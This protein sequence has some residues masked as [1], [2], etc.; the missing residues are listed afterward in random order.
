MPTPDA[1][2]PEDL[3]L[4]APPPVIQMRLAPQGK[5]VAGRFTGNPPGFGV[6]TPA[7]SGIP[8]RILSKSITA[9]AWTGDGQLVVRNSE[10]GSSHWGLQTPGGTPSTVVFSPSD[11]AGW[12]RLLRPDSGWR[13][14]F[15]VEGVSGRV[16]P[17]ASS[18]LW[19]DVLRVSSH[20]GSTT[21]AARNPGD[22]VEWLADADGRV[23]VALAIRG[24]TQELRVRTGRKPETW[25]TV[26][27]FDFVRDPAQLLAL[28]DDGQRAW[29]ASRLGRDTRGVQ[30]LDVQTGRVVRNVFADPDFD[31]DS[32][33]RAVTSGESLRALTW[34]ADLPQV[35]WLGVPVGPAASTRWEPVQFSVSGRFGLFR[36]RSD[37]SWGAWRW[38]DIDRG[39]GR[40]LEEAPPAR[41]ISTRPLFPTMPVEW[42]SR[43]GLRI[44]AYFTRPSA[45]SN[46]P[47]PLLVLVHGGPWDRDRWG[48]QPE[49]QY[50][51]QRG[52]AVLQVNYRG[53]TGFGWSF[54]QAGAGRWN[55]A[56]DDLIDGAR[57]LVSQ[58][59]VSGRGSV[60]AGPSFGGF[61]SVLALTRPDTPFAAAA[62][63]GGAFDLQEWLKD[64]RRQEPGFVARTQAA[65]LLGAGSPSVD[66]IRVPAQA[67]QAPV[68]LLHAP[69]DTEVRFEHSVHLEAALR[70]HGKAVVLESL[71]KGGHA[72]GSPERQLAIWSRVDAFLR[73]ESE[74]RR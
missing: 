14:G 57:W 20:D 61:L 51:A 3:A 30:E 48:W 11:P 25:R 40:E 35:T 21:V 1:S 26:M 43:D 23:L 24:L 60:V 10:N 41:N 62:S 16:S 72:L 33:G 64:V 37:R 56:A 4:F 32:E 9:L 2:D 39:V 29:F 36:E 65:L 53:S 38:W 7:D 59:W 42:R 8:H 15:L 12:V 19:M 71:S 17:R 13:G 54:Q 18:L 66:S 50:L 28:S 5:Q 6:W 73:S 67:V 55:R 74:R 45:I 44:R 46:A 68:L 34:N 58:G 27:T 31:F 49:V 52:W 63:I 69:D 47:P 22:T 70:S